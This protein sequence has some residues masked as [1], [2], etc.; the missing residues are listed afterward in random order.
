MK[1]LATVDTVFLLLL[2]LQSACSPTTA[3]VSTTVAQ[4]MS[5]PETYDVLPSG[6]TD[7]WTPLGCSAWYPFCEVSPDPSGSTLT[8]INTDSTG[9]GYGDVLQIRNYGPG[10][11]T[12][13][14]ASTR[15]TP[16]WRFVL[17]A[18]LVLAPG[19]EARVFVSRD[20][21]DVNQHLIGW[22]PQRDSSIYGVSATATP[23]RSIGSAFQPGLTRT[24][25]VAYSIQVVSL[26]A[27]SAHVEL[28]VGPTST[29]TTVC[30]RVGGA[31]ASST[32]ES[33]MTCLVKPGEYA[34]LVSTG[35]ATV[36]IT[37]QIERS[38]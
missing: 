20:W 11:L 22:V 9:I 32:S 30:G 13:A 25:F 1:K 5:W 31:G 15:S 21:T 4:A 14:D 34:E 18:D 17:G 12:L 7:D 26:L 16:G 29:P 19:Q 28:R 23:A 27:Q 35:D 8:G 10:L 24:T 36:T 33:Q 3:P 6:F 2:F 37:S 38:L